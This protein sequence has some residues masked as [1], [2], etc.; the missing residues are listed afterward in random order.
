MTETSAPTALVSW[1]HRDPN[2]SD[3]QAEGWITKVVQFATLLMSNG[4]ETSLDLWNEIDPQI[5]WTRWGQLQ[6][7]KCQLVIILA[8]TAWRQR[9]EGTNSPHLGAGA[10]TEADTLKGLF[11]TDQA[12]FQR[13]TLLVLLPGTSLESI[14]PD[15]HRL[16]RFRITSLDAAGME[17]LLRRI[18]GQPLHVK[19]PLSNAPTLPPRSYG[20]RTDA[21]PEAIAAKRG[22]LDEVKTGHTPSHGPE[23]VI[24]TVAFER[25]LLV[26]VAPPVVSFEA[27]LQ[28]LKSN[29]TPQGWTFKWNEART[30]V[31]VRS[32]RGT[33][34]TFKLGQPQST[35]A[36]FDRF[37]RDLRSGGA[38]F[39]SNLRP[40]PNAG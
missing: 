4:V 19:P 7:Q 15:L 31:R 1:A 14:P 28:L 24:H 36:D 5:D 33:Q 17:L 9:W 38:R 18:H 26:K 30:T 27:D 10:V 6:V 20:A 29:L 2:W 8:S 3:H 35:R 37:I 13:K 40:P 22:E 21:A 25:P 39:D 11:N 23:A 16:Q 34:H 32:P 12:A